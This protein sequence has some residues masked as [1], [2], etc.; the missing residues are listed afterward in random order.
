MAFY[1]DLDKI[2]HTKEYVRYKYYDSPDNIGIIELNFATE[3]FKEIQP[4]PNDPNGYMFERAAIKI[5]KHWSKG[6]LPDRTCWA[7]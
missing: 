5:S 6:E 7:S 3:R 1:I 2:E 4:A